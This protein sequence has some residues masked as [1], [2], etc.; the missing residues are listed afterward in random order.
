MVAIDPDSIVEPIGRFVEDEGDLR[1]LLTG[2][3]VTA[4]DLAPG[5]EPIASPDIDESELA[6]AGIGHPSDPAS[7]VGAGFHRDARTDFEVPRASIR[8]DRTRGFVAVASVRGE[9]LVGGPDG[10]GHR[11]AL[12]VLLRHV[13]A[14]SGIQI[15]DAS[16]AP[17]AEDGAAHDRLEAVVVRVQ[18]WIGNLVRAVRERFD[19][20]GRDVA[21]VMPGIELEVEPGRHR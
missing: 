4:V 2:V 10:Q 17:G 16:E 7:T 12:L 19:V 9:T 13:P 15:P 3:D 8:H 14:G 21:K 5:D 1:N 20:P 18:L 11:P 6:I